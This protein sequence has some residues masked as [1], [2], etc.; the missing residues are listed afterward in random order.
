MLYIVITV[1]IHCEGACHVVYVTNCL[2]TYHMQG[3]SHRY[4]TT[5]YK[6]WLHKHAIRGYVHV[7]YADS[8]NK[9]STTPST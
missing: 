8:V 2:L 7:L 6:Q 9:I 5:P 4:M 3:K 1:T